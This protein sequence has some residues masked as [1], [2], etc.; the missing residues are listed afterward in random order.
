[1]LRN[2]QNLYI[3]K[4]YR[5]FYR[6]IVYL[7]AITSNKS[8]QLPKEHSIT[9]FKMPF[10]ILYCECHY[11]LLYKLMSTH[12]YFVVIH[13]SVNARLNVSI[14]Y[15]TEVCMRKQNDRLSRK[16]YPS[17]V[18]KLTFIFAVCCT[19]LQA[20]CSMFHHLLNLYHRIIKKT[21]LKF[22]QSKKNGIVAKRIE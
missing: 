13:I 6:F 5:N 16:T 15:D 17:Y 4:F 20:F 7:I 3:L 18:C 22:Y 10:E 21:V 8:S 14:F 19:E 1:M 12:L 2:R 9:K 11:C